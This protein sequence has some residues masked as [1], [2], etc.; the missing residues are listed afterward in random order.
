[1]VKTKSDATSV[2]KTADSTAS[3]TEISKLG[4]KVGPVKAAKFDGTNVWFYIPD[5]STVYKWI[6]AKD[7]K[8]A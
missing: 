3:D 2:Y 1:M 7:V 5:Y 8:K 4:T 6:K